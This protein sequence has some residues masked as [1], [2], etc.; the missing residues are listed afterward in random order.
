MSQGLQKLTVA[1]MPLDSRVI[2]DDNGLQNM[3]KRL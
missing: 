1:K 2:T 3:G